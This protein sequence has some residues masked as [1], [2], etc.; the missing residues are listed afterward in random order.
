MPA[1]DTGLPDA[2]IIYDD[3]DGAF[4]EESSP[5]SLL[6]LCGESVW[7]G[8]P[9]LYATCYSTAGCCTSFS[10]G[11]AGGCTCGET[12]CRRSNIAYR[13]YY[14]NADCTGTEY[15]ESSGYNSFVSWDGLGMVG[16]ST[17][18]V[19]VRSARTVPD[20]KCRRL[21]RRVTYSGNCPEELATTKTIGAARAVYRPAGA[22][23]PPAGYGSSLVV[24]ATN[25]PRSHCP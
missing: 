22:P 10:T 21:V 20:G 14:T 2:S 19:V 11:S 9:A 13:S 23:P 1:V 18:Q 25:Y 16:E 3:G 24:S 12:L 8:G 6:I 7:N 5:L 17:A 15:A 4:A